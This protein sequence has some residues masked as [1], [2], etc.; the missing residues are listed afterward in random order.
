MLPE[1]QVTGTMLTEIERRLVGRMGP[2]HGNLVARNR[3][4]QK[5]S[6]SLH[7]SIVR[8]SDS[9]RFKATPSLW[10]PRREVARDLF[11]YPLK[12]NPR[13]RPANNHLIYISY[14]LSLPDFSAPVYLRVR[15]P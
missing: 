11:L 13:R 3:L 8:V 15:H 5:L 4:R 10:V 12:L 14:R 1:Y 9:A 6:A 2:G 7:L